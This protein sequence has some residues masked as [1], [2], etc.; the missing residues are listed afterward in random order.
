MRLLA[1]FAVSQPPEDAD[2]SVE[3]IVQRVKSGR[4]L[5]LHHHRHEHLYGLPDFYPLEARLRDA[6]DRERM[7]V[8]DRRAP[9][10]RRIGAEARRPERVAEHGNRMATL[11]PIVSR[12]QQTTNGGLNAQDRK[13]AASDNLTAS[14]VGLALKPDVH[15]VAEAPEHAR[16]DLVAIA[17]FRVRGIRELAAIAP[18]AAVVVAVKGHLY[19]LLRVLHRQQAQQHLVHEREDCRVCANAQGDR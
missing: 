11:Q 6:D 14:A 9:H 13:V 4:D 16:E 2:P 12:R 10:D 15:V 18:V 3:T 7:P 19:E 17:D 1:R 5:Q 8:D